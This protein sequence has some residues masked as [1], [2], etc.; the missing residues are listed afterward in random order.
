MGMLSGDLVLGIAGLIVALLALAAPYLWPKQKWIGWVALLFVAFLIGASACSAFGSFIGGTLAGLIVLAVGAIWFWLSSRPKS[1]NTPVL[2]RVENPRIK[3]TAIEYGDQRQHL[4]IGHI[5]VRNPSDTDASNCE[6]RLLKTENASRV[7]TPSH[8]TK[9][10]KVTET[11]NSYAQT[12]SSTVPGTFDL[13]GI[14][15]GSFP[16]TY[17]LTNADVFIFP[18]LTTPERHFLTY[19]I[20]AI[21]FPKIRAKIGLDLTGN[22]PPTNPGTTIYSGSGAPVTYSVVDP[23]RAPLKWVPTPKIWIEEQGPA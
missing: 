5:D 2:L 8:D 23:T 1:N 21:G 3:D 19:E 10:L 9:P 14:S 11:K 4:Y 6:I 17:L 18:I 12:I 20:S 13:F 22:P 7:E 16:S 15:E